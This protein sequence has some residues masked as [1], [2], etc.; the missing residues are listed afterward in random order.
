VD[1][2]EAAVAEFKEQMEAAGVYTVIEEVSRQI[3]EWAATLD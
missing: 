2:V 1:D 3:Q